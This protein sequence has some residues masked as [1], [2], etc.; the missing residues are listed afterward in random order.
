MLT[1]GIVGGP[2]IGYFQESSAN[3]A[4]AEL[5]PEIHQEVIE[6]KR[7]LLGDYVAVSNQK[8][9]ELP[10]EQLAQAK[11]IQGEAIQGS[12]ARVTLFPAIMFISYLVLYLWFKSRGGYRPKVIGDSHS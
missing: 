8:L 9:A 6:D 3:Q 12:L 4:I 7:Y 10:Q 2:F 1:V 11:V 5:M